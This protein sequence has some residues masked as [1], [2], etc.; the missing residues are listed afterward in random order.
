M[1]GMQTFTLGVTNSSHSCRDEQLPILRCVLWVTVPLFVA[2]A[3]SFFAFGFHVS[4]RWARVDFLTRR[5]RG[6]PL[7]GGLLGAVEHEG[8]RHFSIFRAPR[9]AARAFGGGPFEGGSFV[10]F[11][12]LPSLNANSQ[13]KRPESQGRKVEQT[14]LVGNKKVGLRLRKARNNRK[15]F[16]SEMKANSDKVLRKAHTDGRKPPHERK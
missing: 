13:N 4:A 14:K 7:R 8:F 12:S 11:K 16:A 2:R 10:M 15:L 5:G 6:G 9:R 1:D 3:L